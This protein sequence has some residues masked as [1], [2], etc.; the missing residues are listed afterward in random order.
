[1]ESDADIHRKTLPVQSKKRE[2]RLFEQG[3]VKIMMG[4]STETADLSS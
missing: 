4:K 2:E 1:M 3:E